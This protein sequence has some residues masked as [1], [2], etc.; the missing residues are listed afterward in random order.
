MNEL[1]INKAVL[2]KLGYKFF[3]PVLRS[4]EDEASITVINMKADRT[5]NVDY[6]N[7]WE[8]AGPI[9]EKYKIDLTWCDDEGVVSWVANHGEIYRP[10]FDK[11]ALKA[12]MLCFLEMEVKG[13]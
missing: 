2:E 9:I 6:C 8:Y 3:E 4:D 1:E 10:K 7:E 12:A 11:S 13:Q 5:V